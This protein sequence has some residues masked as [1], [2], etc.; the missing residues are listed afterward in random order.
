VKNRRFI[1]WSL[2]CIALVG[3]I[4][5]WVFRSQPIS[6]HA[7]IAE[8]G[9]FTPNFVKAQVGMP[10]NL[11][12]VSDDVEHTFAI[13]QYSMEPILFK[14]GEPVEIT[15]TFDRPGA[16]TYYT[17]TPSSLNFW[18]IRG[19]IEVLGNHPIP[20]VELPLYVRL[21]L[22]LDENHEEES[23]DH[24]QLTRQPLASRGKVFAGQIPAS[25]L[26]YDYYTVHSPMETFEELSSESVF[27]SKS[28]EDIWDAVAYI[29]S[30]NTSSVALDDGQR[31]YKTNCAACHG[32]TGTGDGQFADEM[33]AI[34]EKNKDEHGIQAPTDFT[35]AKHLLEAKPAIVQG[36]ILRGGMGTGMP[37]W[38]TIFTDEQTWDLVAYL[39]SFQFEYQGVNQ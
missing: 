16:Y 17:T 31:L 35:D 3:L 28:D 15:V 33:R 29:W 26:A 8:D 21:G 4:S 39:Y 10:L 11:R 7:R 19:T 36:L 32:E 1:Y 13:G 30:Q 2:A 23:G 37:M 18:R 22:N 27:Q 5:A 6:I 24:L 25:Y 9:G 38:G 20:T 14:P 34:A 12:L